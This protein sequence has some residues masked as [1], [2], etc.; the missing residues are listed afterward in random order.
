VPNALMEAI[1]PVEA[2]HI[3]PGTPLGAS[4]IAD[5]ATFRTWAPHATDVYVVTT[6]LDASG[7][8]NWEPAASDRLIRAQDG[9]WAGFVPGIKDGDR[10][11]F[12]V[13]GPTGKTGFKRDPYARELCPMVEFPNCPCL[14]RDPET[15]P[16]SA[17]DWRPPAFHELII[18]QL[19]VGAYW[20]LD[21]AGRDRRSED[22]GKFLD[23]I[24][25]IDYL[26][27]LGVNAVQLLP[28]QEF[29]TEFSLGY[30]GVDYFSPEDEYQV[31]DHDELSRYLYEVN[32]MRARHGKTLLTLEQLLP[33]PNQL[34]CLVDLCHLNGLAVIFDVVYNHAGG[35]FG[36]RSLWFYD[37]QPNG[38]HNNSLYF[39][40]KGW[41]GGSIFAY[42]QAPVRQLLIDNGRFFL[43][44]FRGDGLRYDEVSVAVDH[45]GDQFCRDIV[46][47]LRYSRPDAIQIAEYW[48]AD[49]A[50]AVR[51]APYGLGF[52]AALSDRLRDAIRGAV[53]QAAAGAHARVDMNALRDALY[54]PSGFE[55]SWKAVHCLEN[56]DLVRWRY[57]KNAPDLPRISALAD[58]TDHHSW[59][60][61]SRARLATAMLLT[62]PGIPMLFMGQEVFEDKPWSDDYEHWSQFLI[63][64][65]GLHADAAMGDFHAFIRDLL[66]LRRNR[67][68]LHGDGMRVT[69]VHNDDRLIVMHRW[70]EGQGADVVVVGSLNEQVLAGYP[71]D[72]PYP[73]TWHEV[74]NS[75]YYDHFPNEHVVG[76]GGRVT[77][78][79]SGRFGYPYAAWLTIPANGVILLARD[80]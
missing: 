53:S 80:P 34:K 31:N 18:Y 4:L 26:R 73:G 58:S 16:W 46:S 39:T 32:A 41:A 8:H 5:G 45:G 44:E 37:R 57:E 22:Y 56:H 54:P 76:N 21:T 25:R 36:D 60:A 14:V 62:A 23:V 65:E 7:E 17:T 24:G 75:D 71:I 2:R 69:Q 11:L 48:H 78:V 59:F 42:W 33:G 49:R 74:F 72:L 15:Y 50:Y 66:W 61:R 20:A 43:E 13:R 52:D 35:D 19:H 67:P 3:L 70:V 63:W 79:G 77:A 68:A 51:S 55:T 6:G 12:W 10:Y 1:M 38:N 40:D 30:N 27:D 28:I 9:T 64:W 29:P 47:T